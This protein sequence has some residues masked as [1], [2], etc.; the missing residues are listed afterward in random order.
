MEHDTSV[1]K[2][3]IEVVERNLIVDTSSNLSIFQPG[4]SKASIRDTT[5]TPR[6]DWRISRVERPDG[7][8][9]FR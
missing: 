1:M 6:S 4:I 7:F 8:T 2:A 9:G 5:L 3:N